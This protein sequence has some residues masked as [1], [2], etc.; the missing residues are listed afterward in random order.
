MSQWRTFI[1]VVCGK[2]FMSDKLRK[3][4]TPKYCSM[5]CSAAAPRSL[6]TRAKQSAAK[7][8]KASWNKGVPMWQDREHPRG[9]LGMKFPNKPPVTDETRERL[10]KSRVGLKYPTISSG[11]HWNWKGGKTEGRSKFKQ[12]AEYKAWRKAV[13]ERDNYTCQHCR[14]RGGC[15]Q[16]HHV[17]SYA[18]YPE[19]R[20]EVSNGLTLCK[21]CHKKTDTYGVSQS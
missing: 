8:G 16:A 18:A 9:T 10:S 1:C 6:E 15:L 3:N 2:D 12:S 11:N 13:F 19:L 5:K 4:R 21:E 7:I 14:V 17:K 20:T